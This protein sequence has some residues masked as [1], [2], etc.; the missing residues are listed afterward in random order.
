MGRARLVCTGIV[1]IGL[2]I[3]LEPEIFNIGQSNTPQPGAVTGIMAAL[4]PVI[5][6]LGFLPLGIL[7]VLIEREL[8]KGQVKR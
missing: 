5:F 1:L 3:A 2:F 8:K 4:W 7:N 6:L